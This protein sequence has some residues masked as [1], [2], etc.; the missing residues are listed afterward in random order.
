MRND[1][2][3]K[4]MRNT[5]NIMRSVDCGVRNEE[6]NNSAFGKLY[7][8]GIGP[9]D[10]ELLTVKAV[11]L[12]NKVDTIFVPKATDDG[13]SF[14]KEIVKTVIAGKK[15]FIEITFPMTRDRKKLQSSWLDAAKKIAGELGPRKTA[16]FVTIGDPFIYSTYIYLLENMRK[17]FPE[18]EYETV[19][20]ISA[21]S[22][23]AA[24]VG[25]PLLIGNE[26]LAIFPVSK[27]LKGLT[28]I[29]KDFDTV[30]L[31]KIGSKLESVLRFLKKKKLLELSVLVS[32]AGQPNEKII[33]NL[34]SLKDKKLGYLSVIIVRS[35][36]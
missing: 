21:F 26:K 4:I 36:I 29:L 35:K 19:P 13:K 34:A 16:A 1:N 32:H 30:I 5:R 12:L 14:A 8:I 24:S 15:K 23:A 18:I 25:L 2:T 20:G 33:R 22:A 10:P 11:K 27:S 31:M 17:N 6:N 9:G 28:E 3:K 7:G